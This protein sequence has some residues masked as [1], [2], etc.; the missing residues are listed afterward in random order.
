MKKLIIIVSLFVFVLLNAADYSPRGNDVR[1]ANIVKRIEAVDPMEGLLP[2]TQPYIEESEGDLEISEMPSIYA[3][4]WA[5]N[6]LVTD[7]CNITSR[8]NIGFDYDANGYLYAG[9]Q[10]THTG[11][12]DNDTLFIFQS[13]DLGETWSEVYQMDVGGGKLLDF[14]IRLQPD[15]T[16]D[17]AIYIA[18]ADSNR[19]SGNRF[20]FCVAHPS[21]ADNWQQLSPAAPVID[22]AMDI[23]DDA[24]PF[25]VIGYITQESVGETGWR[26]IT[27]ADTGG[28]WADHGS[29]NSTS[30]PEEIT[31]ACNAPDTFFSGIIYTKS[32]NR[33][34]MWGYASGSTG[35]ENVSG[36]NDV[37]RHD[38]CLATQ[39]ATAF[40][41][42]YVY[43]MYEEDSRVYFNYS[44]DGGENWATPG[45]WELVGDVSAEEP[46][47]R[48]S[49]DFE[50][51]VACCNVDGGSF[52][53]LV[54]GIANTDFYTWDFRAAVNNYNLTGSMPAQI[55]YC[56][57]PISGRVVIYRE[58]ASDNIWFDRWDNTSSV[59]EETPNTGV[60]TFKVISNNERVRIDFSVLNNE[61]INIEVYD[62]S[63]RSINTLFNSRVSNGEYHLIWDLNDNL[64]QKV[65]AGT[66]FINLTSDSRNTSKKV[67]IF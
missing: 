57:S 49:N 1:V 39:K 19:A 62:F 22:V 54:T 4:L 21:G 47:I 28:T 12:T 65:Q 20:Y 17:P 3:P 7:Q 31:V 18:W 13:T 42:N 43:G 59:E 2:E 15:V 53:T 56:G 46:Y 8:Y 37:P 16:V 24:V 30:G 26:E 48:V 58:F 61:N 9:I 36:T 14:E 23:S 44:S 35:F 51:P 34:R 55:T 64:G 6:L 25:I 67:S 10:S 52:D 27:T 41:A 66:Y 50:R 5:D 29:H 45:F 40:P 32:S 63:G 33:F 60:E 38:P 11:A